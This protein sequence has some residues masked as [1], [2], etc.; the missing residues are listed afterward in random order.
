MTSALT[1]LAARIRQEL[2]EIE[3]VL[4][5][6]E[7]G[8]IRFQQ[9]I[10]DYYIDG[11]ALNLH[12]FYNGLERVFE[13]IATTIDGIKPEGE[14]WHQALLQQMCE[15][16]P[17]LRPAVLSNSSYELLDEYRGFRHVVR[18]VYTYKFDPVKM[19]ALV[20]KAPDVHSRV[21]AELLAFANF[22]E[23]RVDK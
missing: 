6:T 17:T 7:A 8:W 14:N 16:K 21:N 18:N 9:S 20:E 10:D 11:V 5:R 22:L 13:L 12:G 19:K 1:R 15:E 3:I 4:Q 23:N 2:D